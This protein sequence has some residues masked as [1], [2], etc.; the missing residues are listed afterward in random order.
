MLHLPV[1]VRFLV[2]ALLHLTLELVL[3]LQCHYL[4]QNLLSQHLGLLQME[5]LIQLALH[6]LPQ[7]APF[8]GVDSPVHKI[9]LELNLQ[10]KSLLSEVY[11]HQL[12]QL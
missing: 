5:A 2:V 12:S 7:L 11:S 8:L 10:V 1:I 9:F 4:E 6:H 3:L